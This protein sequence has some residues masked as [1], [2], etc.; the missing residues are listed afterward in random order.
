MFY[1]SLPGHTIMVRESNSGRFANEM[2]RWQK[3]PEP[4]PNRQRFYGRLLC[5]YTKENAILQ[6]EDWSKVRKHWGCKWTEKSYTPKYSI[7]KKDEIES[8]TWIDITYPKEV[9]DVFR[10][11]FRTAID[12]LEYKI[13]SSDDKECIKD[14]YDKL[15][16][17]KAEY[18]LFNLYNPIKW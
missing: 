8:Y 4:K 1:I 13:Y 18:D 10:R 17:A 3:H 16:F 11:E 6:W 7:Q 9:A 15:E 5:W 12:N 2:E 14:L